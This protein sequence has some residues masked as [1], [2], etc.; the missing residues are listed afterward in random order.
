MVNSVDAEIFETVTAVTHYQPIGR[1]A[2]RQRAKRCTK[3]HEA[4]KTSPLW[5]ALQ[6]VGMQPT[7]DDPGQPTHLEMRNCSCGSTLCKE[8]TL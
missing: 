6:F 4:L 5:G 3:D 1:E 8:V 2:A 7:Y